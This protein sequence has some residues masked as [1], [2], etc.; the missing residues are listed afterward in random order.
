FIVLLSFFLCVLHN[1]AGRHNIKYFINNILDVR[2]QMAKSVIGILP[3]VIFIVTTKMTR[4][5]KK[6][7]LFMILY[8]SLIHISEP[9]R[10]MRLS[11]MASSA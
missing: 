4:Q 5:M 10:P 6:P 3:A 2:L 1:D 11:R 8:H 9:T 7:K